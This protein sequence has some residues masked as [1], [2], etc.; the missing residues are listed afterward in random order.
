M[1]KISLTLMVRAR[2][3]PITPRPS[4][5]IRD[6]ARSRTL[7]ASLAKTET[8]SVWIFRETFHV[9][10]KKTP[11]ENDASSSSRVFAPLSLSLATSAASDAKHTPRDDLC[12]HHARTTHTKTKTRV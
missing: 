2:P 11:L 4:L 3:E 12:T 7:S 1:Y 5:S 8:S 9:S 6:D 10:L